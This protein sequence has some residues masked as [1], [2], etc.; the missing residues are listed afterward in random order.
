MFALNPD[1]LKKADIILIR[2]GDNSDRIMNLMNSNYSHAILYLGEHSCIEADGLGV[3]SQNVSRVLVKEKEHF[4]VLRY[5]RELNL[6]EIK[7]ITTFARSKTATEYSSREARKA[8]RARGPS[9]T[10]EFSHNRQYC[11]KLIAESYQ[12]ANINIV[13]EP[14]LCTVKSFE[15]SNFLV[16]VD[17]D[18]YFVDST[19]IDILNNQDILKEQREVTNDLFEGIRGVTGKDIQTFEQINEFLLSN[20][21]Y[22]NQFTEI[23]KGSKYL[24]LIDLDT[25]MHPEMYNASLFRK[26]FVNNKERVNLAKVMMQD[27]TIKRF[28]LW[29][30]EYSKLYRKYSFSYFEEMERLYSKLF[31]LDLEKK[32]IAMDIL[33]ENEDLLS[34]HEVVEFNRVM[35]YIASLIKN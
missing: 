22:D 30:A 17:I 26:E 14:K 13:Q 11:T 4:K 31:K 12:E 27:E 10:E 34:N 25:Q 19:S 6:T 2:Y 28:Y 3:H 35:D 21:E 1:K 15:D 8:L 24:T 20:S 29:G 16:S 7:R 9:Y 18:V 32:K 5:K 33:I 23:L